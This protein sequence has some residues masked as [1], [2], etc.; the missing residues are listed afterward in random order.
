MVNPAKIKELDVWRFLVNAVD[1]NVRDFVLV[2]NTFPINVIPANTVNVERRLENGE[3]GPKFHVPDNS[4]GLVNIVVVQSILELSLFKNSLVRPPEECPQALVGWQTLESFSGR[5]R[6]LN[7]VD[8]Y[9]E[10]WWPLKQD[11]VVF[12]ES[13]NDLA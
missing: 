10:V 12:V 8:V 13:V 1:C 2:D 4:N 7:L 5:V 6:D 9:A 3:I 11:G